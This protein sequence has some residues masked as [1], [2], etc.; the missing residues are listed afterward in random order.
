MS[1]Q[2]DRSCLLPCLCF[3]RPLPRAPRLLFRLAKPSPPQ[4]FSAPFAPAL[5]SSARRQTPV[6]APSRNTNPPYPVFPVSLPCSFQLTPLSFCVYLIKTQRLLFLH[7]GAPLW[8]P[9]APPTLASSQLDCSNHILLWAFPL[10]HDRPLFFPMPPCRYDPAGWNAP[11]S[12]PP[13]HVF[14]PPCLCDHAFVTAQSCCAIG[15]GCG[16][17]C[18]L[19]VVALNV[20]MGDVSRRRGMRRT[21][22]QRGGGASAHPHACIGGR[23]H[24]RLSIQTSDELAA[25]LRCCA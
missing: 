11:A 25:V 20:C 24:S 6:L 5:P 22:L 2:A 16:G 17:W 21:L 12:G 7:A 15:T 18:T 13:P 23:P 1:E 14:S 10:F 8:P 9:P 4:P 3:L 19:V